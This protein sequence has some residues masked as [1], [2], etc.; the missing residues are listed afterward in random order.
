MIEEERLRKHLISEETTTKTPRKRL[1]K[2]TILS[3]H[4]PDVRNVVIS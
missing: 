1:N 4:Y 2:A 3:Q